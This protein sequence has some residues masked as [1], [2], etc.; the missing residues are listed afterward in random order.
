ME[1]AM[2]SADKGKAGGKAKGGK[3]GKKGKSGKPQ[4][5][6]T[7]KSWTWQTWDN[8]S[9]SSAWHSR[10]NQWS[11]QQMNAAWYHDADA[12]AQ[13]NAAWAETS[14]GYRQALQDVDA[15]LHS[16]VPTGQLT[17]APPRVATSVA[18]SSSS[19]TSAAQVAQRFR[20]ATA[21]S[22]PFQMPHH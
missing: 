8:R 17:I 13:L 15:E 3:G 12:A 4:G 16:A 20:A 18:D 2:H 10:N 22:R 21:N 7:G 14:R 1:A 9:P 19:V 6:P 11:D 5:K